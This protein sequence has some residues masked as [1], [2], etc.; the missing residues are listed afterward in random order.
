MLKRPERLPE[1]ICIEGG[2]HGWDHEKIATLGRRFQVRLVGT[3][4]NVDNDVLI[5]A[6]QLGG[7]VNESDAEREALPALTP[8][9]RI[10]GLVAIEQKRR[11]ERL[12]IR[13][14]VN[15]SRG[16]ADAALK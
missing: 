10:A 4:P 7:L 5:V 13:G 16:L 8:C 14:E 9:G 15:G 11:R 6:R 12:Q 2:R 3:L 1:A